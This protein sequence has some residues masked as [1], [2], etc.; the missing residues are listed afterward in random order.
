MVLIPTKE[1]ILLKLKYPDYSKSILNI[2]SSIQ[3]HYGIVSNYPSLP[4]I[5]TQ[6]DASPNNILLVIMDGMGMNV[7]EEHLPPDSF[8]RQHLFASLTSVFPCTTTAAMTS[9]YSGLS[10][11]EHGWLGWSLYFKEYGRHVDTFIN[12]DSFS[13]GSVGDQHAAKTLLNY[14]SIFDQISKATN[15]TI[16]TYTVMPTKITVAEPPNIN[17]P[18]EDL[19]DFSQNILEAVL[20]EGPKFLMGYWYEPDLC[21]HKNGLSSDVTGHMIR[22]INQHLSTLAD[23]LPEN[24]LMII[25]ADHGLTDIV[26]TDYLSDYPDLMECLIMPPSIEPRCLS[27]FVKPTKKALFEK[28]FKEHFAKDFLLLSRDSFISQGYLGKGLPH[29]KIDDFIGDYMAIGIGQHLIKYRTANLAVDYDF[30]GHHAGFRE[31]EMLVPLI[32]VRK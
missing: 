25:S 20:L 1:V 29:N 9:Y 32:M 30:K 12:S 18:S 24:T 27:L 22:D 5:K 16:Q 4:A 14:P 2:T 17:F 8:L 28:R 23:K 26:V 13:K 10:P 31:E 3:A 21:I 6:L 15:N 19:N 11:L 7:L